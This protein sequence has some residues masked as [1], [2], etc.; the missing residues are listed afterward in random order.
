LRSDIAVGMNPLQGLPFHREFNRSGLIVKQLLLPWARGTKHALLK[1]MAERRVSGDRRGDAGI[2][3]M[4]C[5]FVVGCG[6]SGTTL[7]GKILGKH[8]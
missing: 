6:R 5:A 7:V 2:T 1:F 8:F 4:P 3:A